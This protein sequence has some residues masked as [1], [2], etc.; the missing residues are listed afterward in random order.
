MCY[1]ECHV[2]VAHIRTPKLSAGCNPEQQMMYAG[3]LNNIVRQ[4]EI[5]KVHP[6]FNS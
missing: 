1:P 5:N 3:S 2:D 6:N 4:T